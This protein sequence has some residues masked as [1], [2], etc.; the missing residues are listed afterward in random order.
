[1]FTGRQTKY[2]STNIYQNWYAAFSHESSELCSLGLVRVLVW[3]SRSVGWSFTEM[4]LK[5]NEERNAV[6]SR[7]MISD[8][9]S[10]CENTRRHHPAWVITLGVFCVTSST[11]S[12]LIWLNMRPKSVFSTLI[13]PLSNLVCVGHILSLGFSMVFE[14]SVN[15]TY[16][17]LGSVGYFFT[18]ASAN[19]HPTNMY[20]QI[21]LY[22][23]IYGR[24]YELNEVIVWDSVSAPIRLTIKFRSKLSDPSYLSCRVVRPWAIWIV[25]IT[26]TIIL[27]EAQKLYH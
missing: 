21:G 19:W 6:N 2:I 25:C 4:V 8:Q 23:W 18:T 1:M 26:Y 15:L 9:W 3:V 22:C 14:P 20:I 11:S 5:G 12:Q 16:Y 17:I 24:W 13:H 7:F 27:L 10:A